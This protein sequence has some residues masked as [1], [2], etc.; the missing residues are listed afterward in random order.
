MT[1]LKQLRSGI[2]NVFKLARSSKGSEKTSAKLIRS[3]GTPSKVT[4]ARYLTEADGI[5]P[6]STRAIL[7]RLISKEHFLYSSERKQVSSLASAVDALLF[8]KNYS[9]LEELKVKCVLHYC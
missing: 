2:A 9:E 7:S 4:P 5:I 1:K 6:V 8:R 3:S